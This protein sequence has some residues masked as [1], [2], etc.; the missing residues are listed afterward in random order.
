MKGI[1][2]IISIILILMIT[3]ALTALAY[4]WFSGIFSTLMS[5]ASAAITKTSSAM[6]TQIKMENAVYVDSDLKVY[7][8]IRNTGTQTFNA[9]RTSFYINEIPQAGVTVDCPNCDCTNLE[10]G[11]IAIYN[12]TASGLSIGDV[13]K[14]TIETGLQDSKEIKIIY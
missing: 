9:E 13:L 6:A 8:T 7:A 2:A 4:T 3:I 12:I 10:Q 11:C 14:A 1:E 5:L